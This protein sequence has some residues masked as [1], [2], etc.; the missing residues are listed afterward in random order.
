M[1][2]KLIFSFYNRKRV[3]YM[4][5]NGMP[6][7]FSLKPA[8]WHCRLLFGTA[9]LQ[10]PERVGEL[11]CANDLHL[12]GSHGVMVFPW[13]SFLVHHLPTAVAPGGGFRWR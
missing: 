1:Y 4:I 9:G 13:A 10:L 3:S 12:A 11:K 6:S 8:K 5:E 2:A 7:F